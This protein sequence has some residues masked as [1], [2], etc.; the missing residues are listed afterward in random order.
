MR[1]NRAFL[2]LLFLPLFSVPGLVA[3]LVEER[4]PP[5]DQDP[6][7]HRLHFYAAESGFWATGG[8]PMF[9]EW[10]IRAAGVLNELSTAANLE[11][12]PF[13]SEARFDL[14]DLAANERGII[15]GGGFGFAFTPSKCDL[16][17][18]EGL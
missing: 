6:Y 4:I 3:T 2:L 8:I 17:Q 7:S 12:G 13:F 5:T 16:T 14:C 15:K 9:S 18:L 10:P 11:N 1:V